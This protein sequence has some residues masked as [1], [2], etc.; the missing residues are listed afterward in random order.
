MKFSFLA[1]PFL[2][3]LSIGAA[4][5]EAPELRVGYTVSATG[6]AAA[7]G[8]PQRNSTELLPAEIGG[9]KAKYFVLDDGS[10]GTRSV[11]NAR[12][13]I[14]EDRIDVL[15]GSTI[16]PTT[17]PL[18]DLAAEVRIPLIAIHPSARLVEPLDD[19]RRWI[20]KVVPN[21]SL[22]ADAI[23]AH[24]AKGGIK[25]VAFIGFN[26]A[27]GDSWYDVIE[28][29]L[30]QRGINLLTRESFGRTDTSVTGQILK[31]I[32][33]RP[34]AVMV[35]ASGTPAALP[36]KALKE[37]GFTGP[38]YHTN[39]VAT[40]EF[41]R[42]AGK[43]AEGVI[44]PV[45]PITVADQ[46]PDSHPIKALALDYIKRYE[47][48]FNIPYAAFGAHI[49]DAARLLG[50]AVPVALKTAQPGTPE[51]RVALRDALETVQDAV[52]INGI[53]TLSPINHCGYDERARMMVQIKDGNFKLLP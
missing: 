41:I 26:D 43:D 49:T 35:G 50:K 27:F 14:T 1:L 5:A 19:K 37:R 7:L 34:D 39:G 47:E 23:A 53:L 24:M 38:I 44:L 30:G 13:L 15:V 4:S 28:K 25:T 48:R 2:T 16:A 3:I 51:F 6:S 29:A 18:V 36:Q 45:G 11:A 17:F 8:V 20:F 10:D 46:L 12:K 22:M 40:K 31:I 32:A 33:A 52:M 42:V 9:I 21:D